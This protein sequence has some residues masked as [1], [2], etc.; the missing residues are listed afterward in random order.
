MIKT[1]ICEDDP[2]FL[3]L[4]SDL[5]KQTKIINIVAKDNTGEKIFKL[6]KKNPSVELVLLD[7]N[8]P[9]ENGLNIAKKLYKKDI[10]IIFI[11]TYDN[12]Y[13]EAFEYYAYDYIS[14]SCIVNRLPQTL[15]RLYN[16]I[17]KK[18]ENDDK[19]ITIETKKTTYFIKSKEIIYIKSKG[20]KIKIYTKNK[21]Y[22]I[23]KTMKGI[24]KILPKNFFSCH[25]SYIIN[26]DKI[27]KIKKSNTYKAVLCNKIAIPIS[28]KRFVFL[29]K[30]LNTK[31]CC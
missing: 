28:K 3:N 18:T 24:K 8:L 9:K 10:K 19:I 29:K 25:R 26:L 1:I 6:I 30:Y 11:T 13:K 15:Y 4:L 20:R 17:Y 27:E 12:Y 21:K 23:L 2:I 5:C 14:K 31:K 7:I 22:E 16:E